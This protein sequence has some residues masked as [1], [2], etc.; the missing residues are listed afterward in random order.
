MKKYIIGFLLLLS[1]TIAQAQN[2][3]IS[4]SKIYKLNVDVTTGFHSFDLKIKNNKS[5]SLAIHWVKL[6]EQFQ[7]GWD[8]SIC[9]FGTCYVTI[10]D[11]SDMSKIGPGEQGFFKLDLMPYSISGTAKLY[12]LMKEVGSSLPFDT[13][14]FEVTGTSATGVVN[15]SAPTLNVYPNPVQNVLYIP[16]ISNVAS[17]SVTDLSGRVMSSEYRQHPINT[18]HLNKGMYILKVYYTDGSIIS[19]SFLKQ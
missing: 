18:E 6:T 9:D 16:N 19:Q 11:S 3:T 15:A 17:L 8:Y 14:G 2:Y 1:I 13:V 10:P 5:D 4:P 7:S 12:L